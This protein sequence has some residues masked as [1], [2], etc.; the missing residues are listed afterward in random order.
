MFFVLLFRRY[1]FLSDLW[2]LKVVLQESPR[3]PDIHD[4]SEHHYQ[5]ACKNLLPPTNLTVLT[6]TPKKYP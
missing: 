1:I 4:L 2:L 6:L 3:S 5:I